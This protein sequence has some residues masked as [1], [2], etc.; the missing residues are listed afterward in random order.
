[1]G[2]SNSLLHQDDAAD[3]LVRYIQINTSK[4]YQLFDSFAFVSYKKNLQFKNAIANK[5]H[6]FEEDDEIKWV[7]TTV[8]ANNL[9]FV[10]TMDKHKYVITS[11]EG[12]KHQTHMLT[13]IGTM[14]LS[15]VSVTII[16]DTVG[17]RV[18][19]RARRALLE[20]RVTENEK[21]MN[22]FGSSSRTQAITSRMVNDENGE[23]V[24]SSI[25]VL[26]PIVHDKRMA[27]VYN[28]EVDFKPTLSIMQYQFQTV[29]CKHQVIKYKGVDMATMARFKLNHTGGNIQFYELFSFASKVPSFYNSNISYDAKKVKIAPLALRQRYHLI[30]AGY[31]SDTV[32]FT[33]LSSYQ[34]QSVNLKMLHTSDPFSMNV[35]KPLSIIGPMH[36]L[37]G[38]L[39]AR[40]NDLN[41]A[42]TG[43]LSNPPR[44]EHIISGSD[45][46][47]FPP[48]LVM[49]FA[50][51]MDLTGIKVF[52]TLQTELY[53]KLGADSV[54]FSCEY[55]LYSEVVTLIVS[56]FPHRVRFSFAPTELLG[57]CQLLLIETENPKIIAS[58]DCILYRT[59]ADRTKLYKSTWPR[60]VQF[61]FL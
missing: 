6:M 44:N 3:D 56:L 40:F 55:E 52:G 15:G 51:L 43:S 5:M 50:K 35:I 21:V 12:Y 39:S 31:L 59:S 16:F 41:I 9:P 2:A 47:S 25:Y 10:I 48:I 46:V 22:F 13:C 61:M 29:T 4:I 30:T 7:A 14:E 23:T 18:T 17:I 8:S 60:D 19:S 24:E 37:R 27:T 34:L 11:M 53:E 45:F 42:L 49:H 28:Y 38:V 33:N 57:K 26:F 32:K 1:M 20:K 36:N 54:I 58:A